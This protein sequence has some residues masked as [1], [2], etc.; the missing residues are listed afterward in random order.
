MTISESGEALQIEAGVP[1]FDVNDLEVNVEGQRLTI[2][3]KKETSEEKKNGTSVYKEQR[4]NEIL[5]VVNLP[6][7]VD[8]AKATAGLKNGVLR[9]TLTKGI[10]GKVGTTKVEVKSV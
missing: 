3:G 8:T 9:L 10:K 5:R 4:S 7:A 1:G 6:S 2:S